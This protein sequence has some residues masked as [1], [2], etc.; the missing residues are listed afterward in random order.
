MTTKAKGILSEELVTDDG[1]YPKVKSLEEM[2]AVGL[3]ISFINFIFGKDMAEA[4]SFSYIW[5]VDRKGTYDEKMA[6]ANVFW[7]EVMWIS[8]IMQNKN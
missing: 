5:L 7:S 3:D 8:A 4:Y 6:Q 1:I 2:Q